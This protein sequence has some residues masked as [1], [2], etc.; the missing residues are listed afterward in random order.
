M[1]MQ[2]AGC[3]GNTKTAAPGH[4]ALLGSVGGGAATGIQIAVF[5]SREAFEKKCDDGDAASCKIAYT[6]DPAYGRNKDF[7]QKLSQINEKLD[8]IEAE[9]KTLQGKIDQ[10]GQQIDEATAKQQ[11]QQVEA[12]ISDRL[13]KINRDY[14]TLKDTATFANPGFDVN[15]WAQAAL[16]NIITA[17]DEIT[18]KVIASDIDD[19][20]LFEALSRYYAV[21]YQSSLPANDD[22]VMNN[23]QILEQYFIHL[24]CVQAK[25]ALVNAACY[26][27]FQGYSS[28][29]NQNPAQK[30]SYLTNDAYLELDFRPNIEAQTQAFLR[31]IERYVASIIDVNQP[32]AA[33]SPL[34]TEI[35]KRAETTAAW[36]RA[37][38]SGGIATGSL[39]PYVVVNVLGEPDRVALFNAN[40][41]MTETSTG[42]RLVKEKLESD[43]L[44]SWSV[45]KPYLQFPLH[46]EKAA[47]DTAAV[48]AIKGANS[49]SFTRY[50]LSDANLKPTASTIN[51]NNALYLASS[52]PVNLTTISMQDSYN[53]AVSMVFGCATVIFKE[54]GATRGV[55]SY[56]RTEVSESNLQDFGHTECKPQTS[57]SYSV[58]YPQYASMRLA[59][60][61]NPVQVA[62]QSASVDTYFS[63]AYLFEGWGDVPQPMQLQLSVDVSASGTSVKSHSASPPNYDPTNGKYGAVVGLLSGDFTLDPRYT[64]FESCD[65]FAQ[66]MHV[67]LQIPT[68]QNPVKQNYP[69]AGKTL[70]YDIMF[71]HWCSWGVN[72]IDTESYDGT[73]KFDINR[74]TLS[75]T[76]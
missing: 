4:G 24:F 13:E 30:V 48:A 72:P 23:Y 18:D 27:Y 37:A 58:Q 67:S 39:Q 32:G 26:K 10:L 56:I 46:P 53:N 41:Q 68:Y 14:K 29:L 40:A 17:N 75:L 50:S 55:W 20:G 62:K 15:V 36:T 12:F 52:I 6:I 44:R 74:V 42:K 28:Q 61:A 54:S 5:I 11:I 35:M 1:L 34:V 49:I 7:Q 45:Q 2:A 71:T 66:G 69:T 21:K 16:Y 73:S 65:N 8:T 51:V 59:V 60:K 70:N 9:L 64:D 33:L 47:T 38:V 57:V 43:E 3:A 19:V 25:G 31:T 22:E 76:R 63:V